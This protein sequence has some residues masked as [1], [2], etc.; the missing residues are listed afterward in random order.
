MPRSDSPAAR[1]SLRRPSCR[2]ALPRST[3]GVVSS[4]SSAGV[5]PIGRRALPLDLVLTFRES[6]ASRDAPQHPP[7][8]EFVRVNVLP[9]TCLKRPLS[10]PGIPPPDLVRA[11]PPARRFRP[12]GFTPPRRLELAAGSGFVAPQYRTGFAAFRDSWNPVPKGL[13]SHAPSPAAHSH[14]SKHFPRW[15]PCRITTAVAP[16]TFAPSAHL[17]TTSR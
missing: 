17:P 11:V 7:V 9:S 15:Q 8:M 5:I 16:S 2:Y 13:A 1:G 14:P 10:R 3:S 12:R 4:R 6:P